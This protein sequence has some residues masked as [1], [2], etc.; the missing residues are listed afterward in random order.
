MEKIA[1]ALWKLS[2]LEREREQNIFKLADCFGK[3]MAVLFDYRQDAFSE[4]L[5]EFGYY[6]GR[7]IYIMDAY[8]DL[9]EDRK[10][11]CFN[12]FIKMA[13]QEDF[14]K[15]VREM[16]L[17]EIAAA[18]NVFQKLPCLEY[19]DILGNILYAG[20]WNRYDQIQAEKKGEIQEGK[21]E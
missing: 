8:D 17:D 7:F 11:G 9:L 20:V 18:G 14:E 21:K 10:N 16:L 15:R 4:Y 5:R 13:E 2:K 1:G 12:P 6:L 3:L 19:A